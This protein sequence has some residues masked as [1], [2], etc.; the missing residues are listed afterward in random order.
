MLREEIFGAVLPVVSYKDE[1]EAV[2]FVRSLPGPPLALYV[3]TT[4][5][6]T[7]E[8]L[9][10]LLPSGGSCRNDCVLHFAVGS[11]PF[12]GVGGSGYG[13]GHGIAGFKT[14][15]HRRGSLERHCGP[16]SEYGGIRYP[17]YNKWGCSG[18]VFLFLMRNLPSV[19]PVNKRSILKLAS[20]LVGVAIL[21]KI[22]AGGDAN[23]F[24]VALNVG[25]S[26]MFWSFFAVFASDRFCDWLEELSGISLSASSSNNRAGHLKER[27]ENDDFV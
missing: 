18:K 1:A 14:F 16:A 25:Y 15:T 22:A 2:A 3:F 24:R 27:R 8:R 21:A 10:T 7:Y 4:S 12:G 23:L 17:P 6:G 26:V 11:L 19:P 20:T 9:T 5:S 13:A